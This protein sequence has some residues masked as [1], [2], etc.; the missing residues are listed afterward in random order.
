M[1]IFSYKVVLLRLSM[2]CMDVHRFDHSQSSTHLRLHIQD[3][4][5]KYATTF[6]SRL[7]IRAPSFGV[8]CSV[9]RQHEETQRMP[10]LYCIAHVV[11]CKGNG[12]AW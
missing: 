8:D 1:M 11:R 5:H 7:P 9:V 3:S 10:L 2:S 12:W 4:E 6:R